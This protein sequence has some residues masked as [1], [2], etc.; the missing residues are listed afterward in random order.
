MATQKKLPKSSFS[1]I[2]AIQAGSDPEKFFRECAKES[3]DPFGVYLPG[4]GDIYFT[5]TEDGTR[6]IFSA[7]PD[8]F[9]PLESNPLEPML[10]PASL[11]L[12][13][14]EKHRKER[15]L[16]SPPFHG[17]RMRAYGNTIQDI[18]LKKM[19][20]WK[21]GKPLNVEAIMQEISLEVILRAVFGI[22]QPKRIKAFIA[23]VSA[24]SNGYS[25]WLFMF[26]FLRTS[27]LG[28]SSWDKFVK[29]RDE[30]NDLLGEEIEKRR[31][32]DLGSREDILSL[33]LEIRYDD[34]SSL[35]G[36]DL[37]DELRTLLIAGH[38]TTATGLAW[39]LS[40]LSC[41]KESKQKLLNELVAVGPAPLAE[42]LIQLPYLDAVCKEALR[43]HPVVP[44][45]WRKVVEPFTL[46][47]YNIPVGKGV[48][49]CMSLLH[50]NETIWK[51]AQTFNPDRFLE[52]KYSPFQYAPFGG[53]ARRCIGAAFAQY[54]M[55]VILGTLM[56]QGI[57]DQLETEPAAPKVRGITDGF[58]DPVF[59]KFLGTK[60]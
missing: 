6:E 21:A 33:L 45:V 59:I 18:T 1:I 7:P 32:E 54:E 27:L 2:K 60:A 23:S 44:I 43:I 3:G 8:T 26:P 16:L 55:K 51:D 39:A 37:K 47:G 38:E 41:N 15:K 30:Y 19:L 58:K 12:M 52:N 25:Q 35:D 17:E 50:H 40:F 49:V 29:A 36:D 57:F 14:K 56:S 4:A 53:G 22:E 9:V 34:G 20:S 46:Q 11:L 13:G 24:F 48:G 10:G 31:K 5:G 28:F 42:T